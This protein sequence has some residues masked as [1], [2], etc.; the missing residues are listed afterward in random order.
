MLRPCKQLDKKTIAYR[1]DRQVILIVT[2]G[3]NRIE[4]ILKNKICAGEEYVP[5][6][7]WK[8]KKR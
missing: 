3:K 8:F 2:S 6:H 1:Q 4:N 5:N 7:C